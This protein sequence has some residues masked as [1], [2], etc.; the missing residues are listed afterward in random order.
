MRGALR[1]ADPTRTG[2]AMS[3]LFVA[4]AL[5]L[6][7]GAVFMDSLVWFLVLMMMA[8][9]FILCTVTPVNAVFLSCVSDD[10]RGYAGHLA[11][12]TACSLRAN[13]SHSMAIMTLMIHVLGDMWSPYIYGLLSETFGAKRP[14]DPAYG[15]ECALLFM[16][17]WGI[18]T[19]LI[20]SVAWWFIRRGGV[21]GGGVKLAP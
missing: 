14:E 16:A 12:C 19:F 5:P 3:V 7:F 11:V 18:W 2:I 15:L 13:D 6:P 9:F 4:C 1:R 10:M 21:R 20:W 8:E 17:G